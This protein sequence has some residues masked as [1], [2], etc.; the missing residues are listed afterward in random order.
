[1]GFEYKHDVEKILKDNAETMMR[2]GGGTPA[3]QRITARTKAE[4]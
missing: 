4:N 1:M 3:A 2:L